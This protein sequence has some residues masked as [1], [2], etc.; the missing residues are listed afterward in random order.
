MGS[1]ADLL[2]QSQALASLQYLLG[3]ITDAFGT[4]FGS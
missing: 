2:A 4:L 3:V 1:I